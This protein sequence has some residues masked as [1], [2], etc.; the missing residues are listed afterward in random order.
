MTKTQLNKLREAIRSV[1]GDLY[2]RKRGTT[3]WLVEE[4]IARHPDLVD[5]AKDQLL[6]EAIA[7]M[8][9][10][11]MKQETEPAKTMQMELPH[12]IKGLRLPA[13]ISVPPT[14]NDDEP[15]T[16]WTPLPDAT[17]SELE[18]HI[19]ML[20]ASVAADTRRLRKLRQLHQCLADY[21]PDGGEQLSVRELVALVRDRDRDAA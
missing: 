11:I 4:V 15:D 14:D 7:K 10:Q 6:S 5:E 8:A 1:I 20:Q 2:T 3:R 17:Y 12:V 9:R 16:L 19:E 18:R 21:L 13:A